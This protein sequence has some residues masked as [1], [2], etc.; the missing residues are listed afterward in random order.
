MRMYHMTPGKVVCTLIAPTLIFG[1][2][3]F[4]PDN[5]IKKL[6]C[7][8]HKQPYRTLDQFHE[9]DQPHNLEW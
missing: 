3:I 5:D 1:A 8:L 9:G 2:I 7:R 6:V 4:L